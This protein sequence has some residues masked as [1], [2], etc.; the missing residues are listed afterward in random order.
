MKSVA[1]GDPLVMVT[2]DMAQGPYQNPLPDAPAGRGRWNVHTVEL[3]TY[4]SVMSDDSQTV[5][6]N[7][8]VQ[9][10]LD[11]FKAHLAA[12][13]HQ[14]LDSVTS[15]D[16]QF[17]LEVT[18]RDHVLAAGNG[19]RADAPPSVSMPIGGQQATMGVRAKDFGTSATDELKLLE[20]APW[21]RP[22]RKE[23]ALAKLQDGEANLQDPASVANVYAYLAS[24][25]QF[26]ASLIVRF[27]LPMDGYEPTGPPQ[28]QGLTDP[29]VKNQWR[30]LPR[31]KPSLMLSTLQPRE[32]SA[33]LAL[34]RETPPVGD[35]TAW[36][37]ARNYIL[38]GNEVAGHGINDA[39]VGGESAALFEFRE[40]P[41]QLK[42]YAPKERE[43]VVAVSDPLAE[44]GNA[45]PSAVREINAFLQ[46]TANQ[47]AF[48]AWYCDTFDKYHDRRPERVVSLAAANQKA[49]WIMSQHPDKWQ[50]IKR[51]HA[52]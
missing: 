47:T 33:T 6:R 27:S 37:A 13:N 32:K 3:V 44:F 17:M 35:T 46:E 38:Y 29:Q 4:P 10:L 2:K 36:V 25:I 16:G 51:S 23:Y 14:P 5:S 19:S 52:G 30:I 9:F 7:L 21:Y 39:T 41:D 12:H 45:R 24:V 48:K 40:I 26:T 15:Q 22:E 42:K 43:T 28:A 31:T 34:L 18:S 20:S 1:T 50:Q 49:M 11:H 8:A